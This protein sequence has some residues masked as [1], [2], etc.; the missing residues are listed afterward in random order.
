MSKSKETKLVQCIVDVDLLEKAR[1]KARRKI[2]KGWKV[3]NSD[4]IRIALLE[5]VS[6]KDD[7]I[8]K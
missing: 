6:E 8:K 5:F 3:M 2:N 4:L 7:E 1:N